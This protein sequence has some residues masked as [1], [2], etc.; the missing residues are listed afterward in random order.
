MACAL[1]DNQP[2]TH[3]TPVTCIGGAQPT[4]RSTE[5]LEEA[6]N[7]QDNARTNLLTIEG[8][9]ELVILFDISLK[10]E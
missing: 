5:I 4:F 2:A 10:F 3:T 1:V 7:L 8:Q 6:Y 9:K